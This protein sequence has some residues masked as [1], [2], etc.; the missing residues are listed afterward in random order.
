MAQYVANRKTASFMRRAGMAEE[1]RKSNTIPPGRHPEAGP[2]GETS[3]RS[4]P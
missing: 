2:V 4:T 3:I 1:T